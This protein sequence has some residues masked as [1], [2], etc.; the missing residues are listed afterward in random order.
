MSDIS[1]ISVSDGM[2]SNRVVNMELSTLVA[3]DVWTFTMDVPYA[4]ISC[5]ISKVSNCVGDTGV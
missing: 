2:A 4:T 1:L 3:N 5:S